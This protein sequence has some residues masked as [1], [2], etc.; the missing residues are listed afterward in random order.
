[1]RALDAVKG[2]S[3]GEF[4]AR[5]LYRGADLALWPRRACGGYRLGESEKLAGDYAAVGQAM[6]PSRRRP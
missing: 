1:V 3:W 2:Q 6:S 5:H 4:N